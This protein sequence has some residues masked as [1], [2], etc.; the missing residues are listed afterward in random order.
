M[1]QLSPSRFQVDAA[2]VYWSSYSKCNW[3]CSSTPPSLPYRHSVDCS[4]PRFDLLSSQTA[5]YYYCSIFADS[6]R[7]CW[8]SPWFCDSGTTATNCRKPSDLG[9]AWIPCF[10]IVAAT[11]V[12]TAMKIAWSR[13]FHSVSWSTT[14]QSWHYSFGLPVDLSSC[15]HWP[16]CC[17]QCP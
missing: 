8:H 9:A 6:L 1:R 4:S 11:V 16:I 2:A 10:S 17:S 5:S 13:L 14:G 12:A 15:Y 3:M 7:D